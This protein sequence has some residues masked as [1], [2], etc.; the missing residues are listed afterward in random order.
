[1]RLIDCLLKPL[2]YTSYMVGCG[3]DTPVSM[4]QIART[5]HQLLDESAK[6]AEHAGFTQEEYHAARFAVCAWID[7]TIL[8]S[9]LPESETWLGHLLQR[10]FYAT[11]RAGEEFYTRM[12]DLDQAQTQVREVFRY[13]LALGFKGRYFSPEMATELEAI[14]NQ[15]L[16]ESQMEHALLE[17]SS[18]TR[19]FP[20][21]Y[22][23]KSLPR[24]RTLP[25]IALSFATL[26][27]ILAPFLL[28][29]LTYFSYS[30]LLDGMV[31][32]MIHLES[33]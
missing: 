32:N 5:I 31:E 30:T 18:A 28:L 17:S 4:S 13:C 26:F 33:K 23:Q 12:D 8:N 22:P 25:R 24:R 20:E 11:N 16:S 19:L 1:M 2:A 21:A 10:V 15:G 3:D 29:V 14:K 7:E 9:R 27:M 6:M